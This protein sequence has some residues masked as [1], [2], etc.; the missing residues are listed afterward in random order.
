MSIVGFGSQPNFTSWLIRKVTKSAWSH[1]W[2]EWDSPLWCGDFVTHAQK[3]GVITRPVETVTKDYPK[4]IRYEVQDSKIQAGLIA[5]RSES[6]KPYDYFTMIWNACIL[7]IY[8]IT[9]WKCLWD[10]VCH[11]A[12]KYTCSEYVTLVLQKANIPGTEHYDAELTTS[13]QLEQF[14]ANSPLFTKLKEE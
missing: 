10:I 2:I 14:C 5:M 6:G 12:S 13:G 1:S 8:Q 4:H 3:P 7:I 9:K 11:N